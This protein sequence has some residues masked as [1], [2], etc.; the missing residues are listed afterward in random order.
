[1]ARA[2]VISACLVSIVA[3]PVL[4]NSLKSRRNYIPIGRSA[5]R[6][7]ADAAQLRGLVGAEGVVEQAADQRVVDDVGVGQRGVDGG[8]ERMVVDAHVH[9]GQR[10]AQL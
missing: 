2:A 3:T 10:F 9:R 1:M 4:W 8:R 7:P 5:F 6:A